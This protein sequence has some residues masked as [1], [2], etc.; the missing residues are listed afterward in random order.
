MILCNQSDKTISVYEKYLHFF[1]GDQELK[2][3]EVSR[4]EVHRRKDD[5]D[6]LL[7]LEPVNRIITLAPGH[8]EDVGILGDYNEVKDADRVSFTCIANCQE[9]TIPV[10]GQEK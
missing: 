8:A 1:K 3:V 6:D 4:F 10:F 2:K 5:L 7:V 9:Y